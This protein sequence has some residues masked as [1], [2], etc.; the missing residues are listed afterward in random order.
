MSRMTASFLVLNEYEHKMQILLDQQYVGTSII[1]NSKHLDYF[2]AL[3]VVVSL[4]TSNGMKKFP[5][6]MCLGLLAEQI[7]VSCFRYQVSS[8]L[9]FWK[10]RFKECVHNREHFWHLI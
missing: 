5:L 4:L 9:S 3:F 8:I 10:G 7:R 1:F 6:E 2:R